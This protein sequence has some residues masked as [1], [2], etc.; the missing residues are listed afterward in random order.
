[1]Y[2]CNLFHFLFRSFLPLLS[3]SFFFP[4]NQVASGFKLGNFKALIRSK[5][6]WKKIGH[7]TASSTP[8]RALSL[9]SASASTS[10]SDSSFRR[11]LRALLLLSPSIK[12]GALWYLFF[13]YFCSIWVLILTLP[14]PFSVIKGAWCWQPGKSTTMSPCLSQDPTIE[15]L[16]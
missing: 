11:P 12:P 4:E 15:Y 1:M 3:I 8:E 13:L 2:M 10:I 9:P 7:C 16:Y 14:N 5:P 6:G